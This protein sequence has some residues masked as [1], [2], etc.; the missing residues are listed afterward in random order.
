MFVNEFMAGR[1]RA[2]FYATTYPDMVE[3]ARRHGWALGLHGSLV[4]DMDLM[5]MP[6]T[7]DASDAQELIDAIANLFVDPPIAF[8]PYRGKPNNRVVWTIPICIDFYLD[9]NIIEK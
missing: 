8:E 2:V 1:G 5:A 3:T 9:I 4:S 7:E 6:W